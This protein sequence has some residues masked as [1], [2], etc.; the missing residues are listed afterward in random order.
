[1]AFS[2]ECVRDK[3]RD[4]GLYL[5]IRST[6]CKRAIPLHWPGLDSVIGSWSRWEVFILETST[7][8]TIPLS[9]VHIESLF[10]K[11]LRG[12]RG[13][14]PRYMSELR[15]KC[16]ARP[17]LFWIA[18]HLLLYPEVFGL[19]GSVTALIRVSATMG[20][21]SWPMKGSCSLFHVSITETW[22]S[23]HNQNNFFPIEGLSVL[24]N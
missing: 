15:R 13:R 7:N 3:G 16:R 21:E 8:R 10:R 22:N 1:M 12:S 18:C 17:A 19:T 5:W 4:S 6:Y 23:L 2:S 9:I 24:L 11:G 14:G 20:W